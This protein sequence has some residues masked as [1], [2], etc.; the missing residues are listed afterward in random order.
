[1]TINLG[2]LS[3]HNHTCTCTICILHT[4]HYIALQ[5]LHCTCNFM[6][7]IIFLLQCV[8]FSSTSYIQYNNYVDY[9]CTMYNVH[10]QVQYTCMYI[11]IVVY[12]LLC[13]DISVLM[14]KHM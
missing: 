11:V 6:E 1:M 9:M 4:V 3:S 10:V 5:V 13:F 14:T 7:I 8:K 12:V 2:W